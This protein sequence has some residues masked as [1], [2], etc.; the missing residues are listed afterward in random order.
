MD[1]DRYAENYRDIH[2]RHLKGTGYTSAYFAER[3]IREISDHVRERNMHPVKILD[4]GCGD[5]LTSFYF[6]RFFPGSFLFGLDVSGES[7]SMSRKRNIANS[8][9]NVYDGRDI[10]HEP[11]TFDIILMANVL[12]HITDDERKLQMIK[13]CHRVVKSSGYLF[14]FEHN[15]FNP[16][17]RKIFRDCPFDRGATLISASSLMK[18]LKD[19][20]FVSSLRFIIFFPS[21][22]F[23]KEQVEKAL[24]WLPLGGQYYSI[25][26]KVA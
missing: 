6:R 23:G 20:G 17:A 24:W 21:F 5:G 3:K 13:E 18:I 7:I 16:V 14:I 11:E 26:G 2:N 8:E 25:S 10:P 4:L 9:F 1:F 12:H 19:A 15:P 22:F